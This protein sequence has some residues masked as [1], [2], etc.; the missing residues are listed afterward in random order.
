M[1]L[2]LV[3]PPL[4]HVRRSLDFLVFLILKH[5]LKTVRQAI[6]PEEL[7]ASLELRPNPPGASWYV[8]YAGTEPGIYSNL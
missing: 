7:A 8:V 6:T 3:L 1:V 4:Q 5:I 2:L